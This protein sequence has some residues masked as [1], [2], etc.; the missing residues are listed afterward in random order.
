MMKRICVAGQ[1]A[2]NARREAQLHAGTSSKPSNKAGVLFDCNP[3]GRSEFRRIPMSLATC[4][5]SL[6]GVARFASAS[7]I[8]PSQYAFHYVSG[9]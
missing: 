3:Q 6:N 1:K 9:S 8:A 2:M 7:E 4:L 5:D